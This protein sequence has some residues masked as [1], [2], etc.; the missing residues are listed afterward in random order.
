MHL[1]INT[2]RLP[3]YISTIYK[4]GQWKTSKVEVKAFF[5]K[6]S[7]KFFFFAPVSK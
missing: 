5:S 1:F 2:V 4:T 6:R 7:L 3:M